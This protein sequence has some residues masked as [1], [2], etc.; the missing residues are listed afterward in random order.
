MNDAS[1]KMLMWL[2]FGL[3]ST[4]QCSEITHR[5][6]SAKGP[7]DTNHRADMRTQPGL[8]MAHCHGQAP[9]YEPGPDPDTDNNKTTDQCVVSLA[10]RRG[11][12]SN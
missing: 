6:K 3:S 4:N 5:H 1:F 8:D 11:K 2:Q 10:L 12:A 9:L 7:V